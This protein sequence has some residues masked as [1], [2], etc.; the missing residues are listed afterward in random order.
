ME[1]SKDNKVAVFSAYELGVR[2]KNTMKEQHKT[3]I[4]EPCTRCE[5]GTVRAQLVGPKAH[6]HMRCSTKDCVWLME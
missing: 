6:L 4:E 5:G 3:Y 2:L 1:P